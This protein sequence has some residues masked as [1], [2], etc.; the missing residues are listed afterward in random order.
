MM[1]VRLVFLGSA[2]FG[3]LCNGL[4]AETVDDY[5]DVPR[6]YLTEGVDGTIWDGFLGLA[7]GQ[8]VN[9]LNASSVRA[10]ELYIASAGGFYAEPWSPL[11]PFLYKVVN[12]DFIATV[13]VTA[14]QDVMHNNCGIMARASRDPDL[15]G[16]GEDWVSIDYFPIW[17]CGNFARMANDNVR[18]ELCHNERAW[19]ADT[20]LQLEKSGAV[21]HFRHSPDGVNWTELACS[22]VTRA[23]LSGIPLQVGLFQATYSANSGYAAFDRFSLTITTPPPQPPPS[24]TQPPLTVDPADRLVNNVS[25]PKGQDACVLGRWDTAGQMDGWTSAG[26]ADITVANGVLTAMGT[27]EAAYLELSSM[28]QGPDLD[29]GYF[30]YVQFRLKLPAGVQDDIV[31]FYGTSAA[32]GIYSGSTRNLLIPA[33]SIPQDGQ[34]H[35]YRLDVGLAVR[36]RDCL[37]DLRIYPLGKTA[38][39]RTF[40]IDY[41]ETGD[42]P[43]DVLLVNTDLNIYSGESFSDLESMESKH[44]VFWWSPQSYQRYAGFDP[45]VMGRR[46]LRMIEESLQVYC[47]KLNYLEPFESFETWRRD[48]NR[49]KINH[50]TWYDGFWCGGWNGFMHIGINGW[51]L[52]DEGWG[53]PMPHEFG[54][55]VQGHQPGFLTGG[56][57]ESHANFLRNA[58]NIHYAEILGDLSG[59]MGDRIFDVTNFRQDHGSLIYNDFRIHHVLQDFGAE[60]GVPNAVADVWI[61]GSKEQ[62]IYTK[63]ASLLPTGTQVGDAAAAGLRHWPFLDF[64]VGDVFKSIFW[65]GA[66][67]EALFKYKIGSHLIPCHDKPGWYRVPFDRAPERFAYM[68][69]VLTPTDEAVTVELQGFDLAGATE[70]W[71]WSLVAAEDN[72][73]NPRYSEVFTPGVQTF[74]LLP[75]E[76]LLFLMVVAAPTDNSLN[77][78]YT[79]NALPVDKHPDRLRYAYEVRLDGA[80]PAVPQRQFTTTLPAGRSHPN[81]GGFVANTATAASTA[82]IGPTARVLGSARVLHN[83]RVEDFAVVAD[84]ATVQNNAVVSG[85]AL[86]K[87]NAT[88]RDNAR[89]RDRAVIQNAAVRDKAKVEGYANVSNAAIGDYAIVRGCSTISEGTIA[90]TGIADY[91]YSGGTLSDGVHFS[92]VPWG[93]WYQQYWWDTLTKPRGLVA[94]YRIE[95]PEGQI[96]WDQF[97][98]AHALLRGRPRRLNDATSQSVYLRLNGI[99]QY[100]VLDRRVFDVLEGSFSL[101]IKPDFQTPQPLVLFGTSLS[102]NLRLVLT[103]D[104]KAEFTMINGSETMTLRSLSDIPAAQWTQ[105]TVTLS[106]S[107][108][109]LYVNGIP[110]AQMSSSL[111]PEQVFRSNSYQQPLACYVGR[112]ETGQLFRGGIDDVRFYNVALT[113]DEVQN[114]ARRIGPRLA[115][116][117]YDTEMDFDGASA[118][119]E[120]GIRNG[121]KRRLAADIFPRTSKSVSFYEGI[122]DSNDERSSRQQGSGIGLNNGTFRVRLDGLGM[123]NT[124]VPVTLNQWQTIALEF[125]GSRARLY[126]NGT[127]RASR[128]Y[129]A[130]PSVLAAKNYRIGYAMDDSGNTYHFDGKIRNLQII[131]LGDVVPVESPQPDINGD[132]VVDF[133]DLLDLASHWLCLDC[134]PANHWCAITDLDMSNKVDLQD[135]GI[136]C[137]Q[138]QLR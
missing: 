83:A 90:G 55:Y 24:W 94:S 101:R 130:D 119:V 56:H 125:D 28:V 3:L 57:W 100:M 48:G 71:R 4:Q 76:S 115:V 40:S 81:G 113:R 26:L 2:V 63:L 51:G 123:W 1:C 127:L 21:F 23:D 59:M 22:P 135:F 66:A 117:F 122:F 41:I 87:G 124:A 61:A 30:D 5:F 46:A 20:W 50:V 92:H 15:A 34:W 134:T 73:H 93:Q 79:D 128:S 13:Q 110:E 105:L 109:V 12:G 7:S 17:N 118:R 77:L 69:H 106:G 74:H 129:S 39:G 8:T 107:Q 19:N 54:H 72:W 120:S 58:R 112:D 43:G 65:D 85:H 70:D 116:R 86:V 11:G 132:G 49:Y 95:E 91:D 137:R 18:T 38:A 67:N 102:S 25:T 31:I 16:T 68:L 78:E 75:E 64:S 98:A 60:A 80:V 108:G 133:L 96:C 35:T 27:E 14:Y 47:K 10:G 99:N 82:Y 114:E 138:L 42:L 111:V 97:G 36:W 52:L 88:V 89:I 131:D 126:V 6:D 84:S 45:Q 37:T 44:A 136:L 104:K 32:P 103:H 121:L 53:N 62:T 33:A 9:Q 29:F